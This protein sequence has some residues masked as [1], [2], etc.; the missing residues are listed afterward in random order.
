MFLDTY[1]EDNQGQIIL[2]I[3]PV[4]L[5]HLVEEKEKVK[6]KVASDSDSSPQTLSEESANKTDT[7]VHDY[8]RP[9]RPVSVNLGNL[10]TLSFDSFGRDPARD[11]VCVT[12]VRTVVRREQEITIIRKIRKVEEIDASPACPVN[13]TQVSQV[14][15]GGELT[16]KADY[17]VNPSDAPGDLPRIT[18]DQGKKIRVE[19]TAFGQWNYGKEEGIL[20]SVTGKGN[21]NLK[22][23][24]DAENDMLF[25]GIAPAALVAFTIQG[26]EY[27]CKAYGDKQTFELNPGE[28][29]YFINNDQPGFYQDNSASLTVKWMWSFV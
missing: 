20:E 22:K 23:K 17:F 21:L 4:S 18:N 28:T 14:Q 25:K 8:Y 26:N 19:V 3:E 27:Q 1:K 24:E 7:K 16:V 5:T 6:E 2:A 10:A 29:V 9:E 12:P 11:I 15:Q 13:T